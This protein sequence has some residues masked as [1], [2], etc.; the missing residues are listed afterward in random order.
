MYQHQVKDLQDKM[1]LLRV[2]V[3]KAETVRNDA[4]KVQARDKLRQ[5]EFD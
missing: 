5:T 2:Q 1:G 3:H 4:L